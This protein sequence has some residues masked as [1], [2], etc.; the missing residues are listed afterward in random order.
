[1]A[2]SEADGELKQR[3]R[4]LL[5]WRE[6]AIRQQASPDEADALLDRFRE[7]GKQRMQFLGTAL[8]A[9]LRKQAELVQGS[10]SEDISA[11]RANQ[12]RQRLNVE[13]SQHRAQITLYNRL[14]S[15]KT[16]EDLGGFIDLPLE[17]YRRALDKPKRPLLP[18]YTPRDKRQMVV[19]AAIAV[20]AVIAV[21]F[22]NRSQAE[23]QFGAMA[24]RFPSGKI[25][26]R[27]INNTPKDIFLHAPW[28]NTFEQ[29][30]PHG[31]YGVEVLVRTKG[32]SE[33]RLIPSEDFWTYN[34][35]STRAI[36]PVRVVPG[37]SS[38]VELN[39]KPLFDQVPTADAIRLV[40]TQG[41]GHSVYVFNAPSPKP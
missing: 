29:E 30:R 26:L 41:N 18:Q 20:L 7:L 33:Y 24:P 12:L 32:N 19:L 10:G 5:S 21:L 3:V 25:H 36:E 8:Q 39:L 14:L 34:G 13:V 38:E 1:M 9:A 28:L 22:W 2:N 16:P 31:D 27:C 17:Q 37:L 15:A 6:Q 23:V 35:L 40:C 11:R 4:L